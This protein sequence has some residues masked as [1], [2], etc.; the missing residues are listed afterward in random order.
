[1]TTFSEFLAMGGY[2]AYVWPAYGA[3]LASL[4][5]LGLANWRRLKRLETLVAA[6]TTTD[7][8]TSSAVLGRSNDSARNEAEAP[9][10]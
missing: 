9:A 7:P 4:T 10:T 3:S 2:A 6:A 1:M 5:V 8:R